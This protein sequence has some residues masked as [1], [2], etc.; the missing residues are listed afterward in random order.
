MCFGSAEPR[1][2]ASER[3]LRMLDAQR[4]A[5]LAKTSPLFFTNERANSQAA[6]A[7]NYGRDGQWQLMN[8]ILNHKTLPA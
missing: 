8:D 5:C 4:P 7:F 1:W 6:Y 3:L 2:R